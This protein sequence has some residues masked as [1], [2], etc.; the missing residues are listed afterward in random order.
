MLKTRTTCSWSDWHKAWPIWVKEPWLCLLTTATGNSCHPLLL[1]VSWPPV[2]HSL[3][4]RPVSTYDHEDMTDGRASFIFLL[5]WW[6]LILVLFLN[7]QQHFVKYIVFHGIPFNCILLYFTVILGKSHYLLYCLVTAIQPRML[8][9]FDEQLN[10]L[11]V[12]VRV[13][14]VRKLLS[15]F[16]PP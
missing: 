5:V 8:V 11:P 4:P 9:T 3:I 1:Q 7:I 6:I 15:S 10:P 2:W 14:Q 12:S 13:G 16:F